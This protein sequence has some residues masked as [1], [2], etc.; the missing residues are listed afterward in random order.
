[1]SNLILSITISIPVI[2]YI[3][4]PA[5]TSTISTFNQISQI[6]GGL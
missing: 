3:I 2:Y 1:M 5:L 6:L 4:I